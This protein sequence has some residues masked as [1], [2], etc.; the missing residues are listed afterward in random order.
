MRLD[1]DA[2]AMDNAAPSILV[3]KSDPITLESQARFTATILLP[4]SLLQ[5]AT[6]YVF[7]PSIGVVADVSA[8]CDVVGVHAMDVPTK[9][10]LAMALCEM[11]EEGSLGDLGVTLDLSE[12][13]QTI[14]NTDWFSRGD[15]RDGRG[16]PRESARSL[17]RERGVIML[18][19]TETDIP[20]FAGDEFD[21]FLSDFGS[22][23][24]NQNQ[25][26][27]AK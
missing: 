22:P 13:C 6:V 18:G 10:G 3:P 14:L 4:L 11:A 25:E 24:G 27:E 26:G 15:P 5:Q 8:A 19:N 2:A 1:R 17:S 16:R 21:R 23:Y 9:G 7:E 20:R 12:C